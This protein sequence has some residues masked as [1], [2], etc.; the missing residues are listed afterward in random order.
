MDLTSKK[1]LLVGR[2]ILPAILCA[3]LTGIFIDNYGDYWVIS[4]FGI[5]IILFNYGKTKYNFILS[6]F[7]SIIL[8]WTVFFFSIVISTP[9]QYLIEEF[10]LDKKGLGFNITG[11]RF[12]ISV[13]I[14]SPLLMFYCYKILF[15]IENINYSKSIKWLSIIALFIVVGLLQMIY[16]K[17]DHIYVV[18]QFILAFALQLILYQNE[19]KALFK[20]KTKS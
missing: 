7:I 15:R 10:G 2:I 20:L 3:L 12:L 11:L 13:V 16:K 14:I 19:L 6:F 8:S 1:I 18:W 5:A 17:E 9:I 4:I